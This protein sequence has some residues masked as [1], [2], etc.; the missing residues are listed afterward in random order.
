M[1]IWLAL[2]LAGPAKHFCVGGGRHRAIEAASAEAMDDVGQAQAMIGVLPP[3]RFCERRRK[4][5]TYQATYT[6]GRE[7]RM[8]S[9]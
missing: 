6:L 1:T 4:L 3:D 7:R 9:P 8:I 2:A 5:V